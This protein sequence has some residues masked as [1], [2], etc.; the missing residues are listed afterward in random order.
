M[1]LAL[2]RGPTISWDFSLLVAITSV[3]TLVDQDLWL[4]SGHRILADILTYEPMASLE[5]SHFIGRE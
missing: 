1:R 3:R 5:R 2:D 4:C